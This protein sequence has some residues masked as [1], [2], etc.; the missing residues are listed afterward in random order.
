MAATKILVSD[1]LAE[2][3]IKILEK[4]KGFEVDVKP[5]LPPEELKKIIKNYNALIIRSGT[6]VT[7]DIIS[8]ASKLKVIGRAGVGLDNVDVNAASKKG[9]IVMNA[10]AGNTIST[11]EHTMSMILALSR[12]IPQAYTSMREG[13]WDRKKFMGTEIYNKTLGVIGL[14]RI[15]VEVT[16]RAL[17]FKMKVLGYDPYLSEEKTKKM[18]VELVDLKTLLKKSDYITVHTP[19]TDETKHLLG[20]DEFKIM[21]KGARIINCA[22]GG[23][24]DEKALNEA[25]ASGKIAGAALDVYEKEPPVNNPLLKRPNVVTTPHIGAST[26]EA[27]VNVAIDVAEAVRDAI[28]DKGI[29]NAVNVPSVDSETL[30]NLQPYLNLAEKIGSLQAQLAEG[31]VHKVKVKYIGDIT[32]YDIT[33]ITM[34]LV[35]GLLF[36]VLQETINYMNALLIAKMRGI[37]VSESKT[38]EIIDFANAIAVTVETNKGKNLVMGSLFTRTD[39]RIIRINNFYVDLVPKGHLVYIS[40]RDLPGVVGE[41]GTI[42]GK[43]GINIAGMT[44]GRIKPGGDAI[45]VLNI[46]SE[47]SSETVKKLRKAKHINDVRIMKL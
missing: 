32:G 10:P 37:V 34:A 28:L 30:K 17:S 31:R 46:D 5:K 12:N 13:K 14:G 47:P 40:N 2:E 7:S 39:P 16:K 20:K 24:V 21:K 6:K 27:Q 35:K 41:I 23:I 33:P 15:G 18:D 1:P 4:E 42:L 38:T 19:L 29:R 11:A 44:F 8:N 25:F 26:E 43:N 45:T 36:P 3:G 9:I 22:R